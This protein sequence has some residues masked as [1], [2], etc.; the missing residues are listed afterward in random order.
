[1]NKLPLSVIILTYNEEKNIEPCIGSVYGI[2]DEIFVVD[3]FSTDKTVEIARNYSDKVFQHAFQNYAQQRNWAQKNLPLNNEWVLHLDADERLSPGLR[4]ELLRIFSLPI[5][6]DGFITPRKTFFRG[7]WIRYGG[8]Y[9]VYHLRVFKKNKGQ[10]EERLYDQHFIVNGKV[11]RLK[12][13]IINIIEADLDSWKETHRRWAELEARE[14]ISNAHSKGAIV[15]SSNTMQK[16]RWLKEGVYYKLPLYARVC[17]YFFYRYII[18]LGF[19]DG[20]EGWIFHFYQGF[21]Y[22]WLVDSNIGK[23]KTSL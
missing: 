2:A 15:L 5:E 4:D 8:H 22:R 3:S 12:G 11:R 10:S 7:R 19:L 17:I 9:P 23:E 21:W 16:R 20:K 14:I 6:E 13:D 18:R 1:M